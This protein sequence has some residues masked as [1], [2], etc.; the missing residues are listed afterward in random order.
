[1]FAYDNIKMGK[2][3]SVPP[4]FIHVLPQ[5]TGIALTQEKPGADHAF[6]HGIIRWSNIGKRER[7]KQKAEI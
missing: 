5:G 3:L 6:R 2:N 7:Y 4:G 1:M